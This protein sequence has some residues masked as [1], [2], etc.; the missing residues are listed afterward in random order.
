VCS[1]DLHIGN[2]HTPVQVL[3]DGVLR[4]ADDHVLIAMAQGLGAS[5]TQRMAP[6][7]P[8]SGAYAPGHGHAH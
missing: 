6:F 1:S 4:I 5:A 8:E 2:R 7:Q 3:P